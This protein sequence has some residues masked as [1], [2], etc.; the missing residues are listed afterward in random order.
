MSDREFV[1]VDGE[2]HFVRSETAWHEIHGEAFGLD[3]LRYVGETD[4]RLVLVDSMAKVFWT[5]K[6][7]PGVKR[8][9]YFTSAVCDDSALHNL[10]VTLRRFDLESYIVHERRTL[11]DRRKNALETKRLIEKPKGVDIAL[12]VRMLEETQNQN[13]DVCHLYTSDADFL[14]LIQAVQARGKQVLVYGYKNGIATESPLMY[15]PDLFV[16]LEEMLRG[17]CELVLSK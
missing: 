13:F 10:K 9:T 16:D 4:D 7:N 5:R 6:M 1:Y 14:P 2:S 17:D 11:A 12:T 15:E 3:R 8:A